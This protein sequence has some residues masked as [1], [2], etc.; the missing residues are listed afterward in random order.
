MCQC[1]GQGR[2]PD[3]ALLGGYRA[4][5]A[6]AV[7]T[8][9]RDVR[10]ASKCSFVMV[11]RQLPAQHSSTAVAQGHTAKLEATQGNTDW[12]HPSGK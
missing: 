4:T 8:T 12:F 9:S 1:P 2:D 10:S 3:P 11:E 6:A 5:S 7:V